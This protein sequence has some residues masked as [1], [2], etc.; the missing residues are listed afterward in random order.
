MQG[1]QLC[2]FAEYAATKRKWGI[3]TFHEFVESTSPWVP[4][5]ADHT[6]PLPAAAFRTL[7]EYL[8]KE[9]PRLWTAPVLTVAKRVIGWRGS[10]DD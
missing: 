2:S 10:D 3:L 1:K 7:C 5:R 4:G 8:E 6:P 9:T